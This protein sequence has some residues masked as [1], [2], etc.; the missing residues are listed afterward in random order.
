M[1]ET[2]AH[3]EKAGG[4]RFLGRLI[5]RP[6]FWVGGGAL[7]LIALWL[8]V[9][10]LVWP[11]DPLARDTLALGVGPDVEHWLGTNDIGQDMYARVVAGLRISLLIGLIAGPGATLIAAVLGSLAG[12]AG[13]SIDRLISGLIRLLL[14]LPGLLLLALISP[15]FRGSSWFT[16]TLYLAG[17]GWMIMAQVVRGQTRSLREREFVVAARYLGVP[18]RRIIARHILPNIASLL[19]IDATVGVSVAILAEAGLSFF[20][21]GI[22]APDLSLGSLLATGA[23]AATT[24][25]WLFLYPAL[26]LIITVLAV[27]VVGDAVRD[28]VDTASSVRHDGG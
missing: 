23:P 3:L 26:A 28:T 5:R 14:V 17:F 21:L 18:T 27:S 10:P 15:L 2:I 19:I 25:S 1:S 6:R 16:M 12:Y 20:G 8:Y 7:L 13:G 4:G 24:R 11:V 9:S 22:Q